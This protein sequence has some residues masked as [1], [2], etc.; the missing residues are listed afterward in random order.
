MLTI[1]EKKIYV[2]IRHLFTDFQNHQCV[3]ITSSL[4]QKVMYKLLLG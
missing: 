2:D 4:I 3:L 1:K